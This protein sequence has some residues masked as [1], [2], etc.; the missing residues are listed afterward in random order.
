MVVGFHTAVKLICH[1]YSVSEAEILH[2]IE[3]DEARTVEEITGQT[4][5][6]NG[7]TACHFRIQRLLNNSVRCVYPGAPF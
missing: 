1:C 5:A 7:C 4:C 6:G 2:A 3:H